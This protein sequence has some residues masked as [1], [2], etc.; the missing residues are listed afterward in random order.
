MI[1]V[2]HQ[3]RVRRALLGTA[4]AGGSIPAEPAIPAARVPDRTAAGGLVR[5]D[6]LRAGPMASILHD[7][8]SDRIVPA[9]SCVGPRVLNP[10][11]SA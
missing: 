10:L 6:G 5:L 3:V 4:L 11:G 9:M 7:T 1:L 8:P 2:A